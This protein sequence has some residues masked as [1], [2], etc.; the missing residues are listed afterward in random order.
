MPI[1]KKKIDWLVIGAIVIIILITR[2]PFATHFLF[3]WD[4][5][6][7]ALGTEEYN[8]AEHQPH[9]PGYVLYVLSAKVINYPIQDVNAV[10][11][12][13]SILSAAGAAIF[14]FLLGRDMYSRRAG[15]IAAA[16]LIFSKNF[17]AY[18]EVAFSYTLQCFLAVAVV[19]FAYKLVKNSG[20]RKFLY[21]GSI[22]L[23]IGGGFR[24]GFIIFLIPLWLYITYRF[25]RK[26]FWRAW[27]LI[28]AI[29]LAWLG[30]MVLWAGGTQAYFSALFNQTEYVAGFS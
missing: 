13:I 5:G 1:S 8:L 10:L 26:D 19:F 27:G 29:C 12:G 21:L 22:V 3:A 11:V 2:I 9:P 4:S 25:A 18:S 14:L 7:V 15:I 6:T 28:A 23:A 20:S 16:L 30:G 24:Q 17:W